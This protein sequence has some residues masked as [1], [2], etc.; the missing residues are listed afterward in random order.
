[1]GPEG[2]RPGS[3]TYAISHKCSG[4]LGIVKILRYIRSDMYTAKIHRRKKNWQEDGIPGQRGPVFKHT[5][6]TMVNPALPVAAMFVN[7]SERNEQ[8]V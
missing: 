5:L 4:N 8:S 6:S 2:G 3:P 7:G 1:M